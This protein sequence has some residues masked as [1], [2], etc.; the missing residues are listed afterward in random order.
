M[1]FSRSLVAGVA[2]IALLSLA[3]A[4][5]PNGCNGKGVCGANDKCTCYAGYTEA[6]C[7]GRVC[8][9]GKAWAD[10]ADTSVHTG[11]EP[12][13]YA[14]CSNKGVCDRE[15]GVCDCLG[16]FE[17]KS[18]NRLSC[19]ESCSG[20]GV[21][22][23]MEDAN[24]GYALWD[25]DMI[26]V[27]SCDNGWSGIDCAKRSCITGDD[28]LTTFDSSNVLE[29]DEV[30]TV[31]I[32]VI[33]SVVHASSSFILGYTDW[34]GDVL[35]THPIAFPPTLIAIEEALEALPNNAVP[36]VSVTNLVVGATDMD[37][38]FTVTFSDTDNKGDQPALTA[39][40]AGCTLDGCQPVY[41]GVYNT[42][43]TPG[44]ATATITET[45]AGT[46][47]RAECS[48]RGVCDNE[49]GVCQCFPGFYGDACNLQTIVM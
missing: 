8:E 6:D 46:A 20:H 21:C 31:Q 44:V 32:A 26:M 13:Y 29:A 14:E 19:P 42:E 15:K 41:Y 49:I 48:N 12:H 2:F 10:I 5:C 34:R 9:N 17:G 23:L 37:Y 43:V 36:S 35:Y 33:T 4:A 25:S 22:Q 24:S 1:T 39:G 47:E 16:G 45:T 3:D 7:S 38:T 11:R 30:Q 27:C 18:C 40:V 28:P